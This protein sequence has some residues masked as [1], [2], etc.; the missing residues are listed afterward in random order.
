MKQDQQ[1]GHKL[2]TTAC[3]GG[4]AEAALAPCCGL[5]L[6][7]G[8]Q[9]PAGLSRGSR[10]MWLPPQPHALPPALAVSKVLLELYQHTEGVPW[11]AREQDANPKEQNCVILLT[12]VRVKA[13]SA[14][15]CCCD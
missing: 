13:I 10:G 12:S 1:A 11:T 9:P 5:A 15:R 8:T 6:L 14:V 2:L 7:P 3:H 4:C